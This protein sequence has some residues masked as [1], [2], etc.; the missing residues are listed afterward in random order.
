MVQL[1][2]DSSFVQSVVSIDCVQRF[3]IQIFESKLTNHTFLNIPAFESAAYVLNALVPKV[4]NAQAVGI[5]SKK[6]NL[7]TST[8]ETSRITVKDFE[9]SADGSAY[10]FL[11]WFKLAQIFRLFKLQVP[12]KVTSKRI[13]QAKYFYRTSISRASMHPQH[14]N[15]IHI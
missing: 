11:R 4:R 7:R 8:I 15:L 14:W 1:I 13:S 12:T 5:S 6:I 10:I 2:C 9:T 3:L